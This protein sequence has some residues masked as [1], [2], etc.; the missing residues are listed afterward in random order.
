MYE[1]SS[2]CSVPDETCL[3]V[4]LHDLLFSRMS[5]CLGICIIVY[6]SF[7]ARPEDTSFFQ[8]ATCTSTRHI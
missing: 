8:M 5:H 7:A 1:T 2:V 6:L 3:P 4:C